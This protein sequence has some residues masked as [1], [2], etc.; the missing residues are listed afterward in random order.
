MNDMAPTAYGPS[1]AKNPGNILPPAALTA[2]KTLQTKKVYP[3]GYEFFVRGQS[4]SGIYILHAGRVQL[5][6]DNGGGRLILGFA[7]PGDI[8]G[9]SAAVSGKCH[10]ETAEAVTLCR[11][12]FISCTDFLRFTDQHPQAAFWI[13]QLLSERVTVAFEHLSLFR[14]LP[15]RKLTQ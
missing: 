1:G 4:P 13:V 9:L 5:S 14:V 15:C 7:F 2:L 6:V 8:L 10:E 3:Q 11:A 12:G